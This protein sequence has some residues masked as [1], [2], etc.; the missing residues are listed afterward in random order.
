MMKLITQD[1]IESIET[2]YHDLDYFVKRDRSYDAKIIESDLVIPVKIKLLKWVES[3][4]NLRLN[5]YDQKFV[6][7]R[8]KEN[9]YFL[10][11]TDN[12]Y[13]Y[14][15]N[16]YLVTGFHLNDNY[17]GGDYIVYDP[18][19][20]IEKEIGVP[21]VFESKCD[22]EVKKITKGTR[23]CVIMFINHEDVVSKENNKLI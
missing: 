10:R 11:H 23:R 15:K 12:N 17:E 4:L 21:Y 16:R 19:Y 22:H 6:I 2:L 18:Y 9:D 13:V 14:G 3:K 5:S 20:F 8:Y 1:E 7:M